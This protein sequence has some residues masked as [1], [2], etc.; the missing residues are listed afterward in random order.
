[1][2][3]E[4]R[5]KD[6]RMR[7]LRGAIKALEGKLTQ[8]LKE[9]TDLVMQA[10]SWVEQEHLDERMAELEAQKA[11]L[12][13]QLQQ[14]QAELAAA[15]A[16]LASQEGTIRKLSEQLLKEHE[17]VMRLKAELTKEQVLVKTLKAKS[18]KVCCVLG[19]ILAPFTLCICESRIL[20]SLLTCASFQHNRAATQSVRNKL[21]VHVMHAEYCNFHINCLEQIRSV[22]ISAALRARMLSL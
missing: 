3:T 7:Q 5:L 22:C 17:A 20:T 4:L 8:L 10:S 12:A 14:C 21:T 1:M 15:K 19:S 18:R 9:K 6:E 13:A 16:S 2:A 11:E